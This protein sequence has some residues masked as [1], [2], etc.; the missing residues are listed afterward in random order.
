MVKGK[1]GVLRNMEDDTLIKT[2]LFDFFGELLTKKQHE[3]FDLYYNEDFSLS[4]IAARAGITRQ[5]VHGIILRAE[6][7]LEQMESKTG[8]VKRW[9]ESRAELEYA[10][11]LARELLD[12]L[13]NDDE[14]ADIARRLV[15]SL[16]QMGMN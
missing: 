1:G 8:V 13:D 7:S 5:G 11:G 6:K 14:S 15:S 16:E 2:M 4:E 3:Y 10:Q 9:L 12:V